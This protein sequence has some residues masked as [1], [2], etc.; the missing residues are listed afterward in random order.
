VQFIL[1][2][3]RRA[4]QT[5]NLHVLHVRASSKDHVRLLC[6]TVTTLTLPFLSTVTEKVNRNIKKQN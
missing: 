4:V 5:V 2:F 1:A 3:F 6:L